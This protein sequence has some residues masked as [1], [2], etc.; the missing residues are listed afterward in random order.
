[1][2]RPFEGKVAIV[3]GAGRG[4]GRAIAARLA[5]EGAAVVIATRTARYGEEAVAS[6]TANG[7]KASLFAL[8]V[9][10]R[11]AM[12]ALVQDAVE[13]HGRLDIAVHAAADI[14]FA[15]LLELTDDAFDLCLNSV[16]KSAFWLT[17][18]AA[19]QMKRTGGG[20]LIFISSVAG[21]RH[22]VPGLVHYGAAKAALTAFAR[23]AAVELGPLGITVN[24]V[25]PGLIAS[26]RMKDMMTEEAAKA[27]SACFPVARVGTPDDVAAAVLSLALP[28]ASWITGTAITVDGGASL[29]QGDAVRN[30]LKN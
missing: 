14:P 15:S 21:N 13:R 10:D 5:A 22:A 11:A 8:D 16:L 26:D 27:I 29:T 24:T 23:G 3:T 4:I 28:S 25:E 19:P 6:I 1:M 7:G 9:S 30:G 18:D 2:S 20:R 12:R 17:Q